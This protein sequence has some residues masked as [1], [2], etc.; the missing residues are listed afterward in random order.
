MYLQGRNFVWETFKTAQLSTKLLPV[1]DVIGLSLWIY[2][3]VW[4]EI[5]VWRM[6]ASSREHSFYMMSTC[7]LWRSRR[8][9]YRVGGALRIGLSF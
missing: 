9:I 8:R 3:F 5:A 4:S 7:V 1:Y 2:L 6:S